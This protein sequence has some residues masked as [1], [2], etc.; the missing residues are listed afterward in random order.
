MDKEM[1]CGGLYFGEFRNL[2]LPV[3]EQQRHDKAHRK[4]ANS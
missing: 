3:R 2:P 1:P 4:I